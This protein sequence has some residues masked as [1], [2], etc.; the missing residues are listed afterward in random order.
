MRSRS[1]SVPRGQSERAWRPSIHAGGAARSLPPTSRACF[2][3]CGVGTVRASPPLPAALCPC[4]PQRPC[5]RVAGWRWVEEVGAVSGCVW[6][7]RRAGESFDS[8]PRQGTKPVPTVTL[9]SAPACCVGVD[10]SEEALRSEVCEWDGWVELCVE[11]V[12]GVCARVHGCAL[13]TRASDCACGRECGGWRA[14][15]TTPCMMGVEHR[16]RL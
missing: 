4:L 2:A 11:G 7:V 10:W 5:P 15:H 1:G 13:S 16:S 9:R 12:E 6:C 3:P 8:P 14:A